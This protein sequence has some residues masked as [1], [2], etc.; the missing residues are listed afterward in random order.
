MYG[1]F[2]DRKREYI[3]PL[4]AIFLSLFII[5]TRRIRYYAL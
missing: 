2:L 4:S 1:Y 5:H 3:E